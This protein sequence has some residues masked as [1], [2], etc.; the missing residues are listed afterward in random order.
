MT[1]RRPLR[2]AC[3]RLRPQKDSRRRTGFLPRAF[4]LVEI[5][6][7]VVILGILAAI[8]VPQF[9]DATTGASQTAFVN[10]VRSF[11]QASE[12][13]Y[14]EF[15]EYFED[16]GTGNAPVMLGR[17]HTPEEWESL[18]PIGGQWDAENNGVGGYQSAVGVVF[19]GADTGPTRDDAF[20]Q[21]V[22]AIFDDG[23]L[24]DGAFREI[25]DDTRYSMIVRE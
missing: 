17:Y 9:A 22:D 10:N 4:T 12:A 23:D 13:Y 1:H 2:S 19:G 11:A 25:Q 14:H 16:A 20:M 3:P 15:G 8:V 21:Q 24:A 6:I 18:T 7:V 5:L